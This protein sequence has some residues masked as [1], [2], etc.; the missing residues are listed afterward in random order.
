[1]C[2]KNPKWRLNNQEKW[3]QMQFNIGFLKKMETIYGTLNCEYCGKPNLKIYEWCEKINNNDVATADHFYPK[4]KYNNLKME[5]KNM[6]VS[7]YSCNNNKKD[8]VCS[9]ETIKHPLNPNKIKEIN[10]II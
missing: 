10:T 9:V 1:M 4:S 7:C 6:I 2:E 3:E 5:E 8:G